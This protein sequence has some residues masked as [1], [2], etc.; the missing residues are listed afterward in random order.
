MDPGVKNPKVSPQAPE[1]E[2]GDDP[3]AAADTPE[4]EVPDA[5]KPQEGPTSVVARNLFLLALTGLGLSLWFL[6]FTDWFSWFNSLVALSGAFAWLASLSNIL[7]EDRKKALQQRVEKRYLSRKGLGWRFLI[8]A[9]IVTLFFNFFGATVVVQTHWDHRARAFRLEQQ[10]V[11]GWLGDL[12][13]Q[14]GSLGPGSERRFFLLHLGSFPSYRLKLAGLPSQELVLRPFVPRWVKSPEDL[15]SRPVLL[16]RPTSGLQDRILTTLRER[17]E[18]MSL[19]IH[20]LGEDPVIVNAYRGEAFWIDGDEDLEVPQRLVNSWLQELRG[21]GPDR[22]N[23][24]PWL[25]I[26]PLDGLS[27]LTPGET[28]YL[29]LRNITTEKD[30]ILETIVVDSH[31]DRSTF[32]QEVKLDIS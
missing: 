13:N 7:S 3:K 21:I 20:R 23:S 11:S 5:S 28:V 17:K 15:Y 32:P 24:V 19:S 25:P 29:S 8:V 9:L 22:G 30:L 12:L 26:R 2:N 10:E 14:E 31:S 18:S 4:Q 16:I 27:D 1:V 6:F